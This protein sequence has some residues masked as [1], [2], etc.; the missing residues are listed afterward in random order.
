MSK[1][2]N[3]GYQSAFGW[4]QISQKMASIWLYF[5][6]YGSQTQ[7]N[8]C[9]WSQQVSI[10]EPA[11]FSA[12]LVMCRGKCRIKQH[13]FYCWFV[14]TFIVDSIWCGYQ[15]SK[16]GRVSRSTLSIQKILMARSLFVVYFDQLSGAAAT[17]RLVLILFSA[18]CSLF[19][20]KA[21]INW[22]R[23]GKYNVR[24]F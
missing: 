17:W 1:T 14:G 8:C 5:L 3:C 2:S 9:N 22:K 18:V 4:I 6:E 15:L 13:L 21:E 10:N 11:N 24:L 19:P 20:K 23:K 16:L 7:L 12:M